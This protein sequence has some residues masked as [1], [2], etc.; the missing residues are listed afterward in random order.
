[1]FGGRQGGGGGGGGGGRPR[2]PPRRPPPAPRQPPRPPPRPKPPQEDTKWRVVKVQKSKGM[3][4]AK[5]EVITRERDLPG[6]AMVQ[7]ETLEKTCYK[8]QVQ[9]QEKILERR[10]RRK[11]AEL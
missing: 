11:D 6:T 7:V 5:V 10:R 3:G 8:A 1:M 2:K 4:G 9:C